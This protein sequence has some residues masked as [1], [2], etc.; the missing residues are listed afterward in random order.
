MESRNEEKGVTGLLNMRNTCYMNAALQALRHNTEL[1]AF[2]LESKHSHWIDRKPSSPNVELVKGYAD[3]LRSLWAG[4]KPAYVRPEGFLQCMHPAAIH[5]GFDQFA[6]PMQHDSHEFL[7]FLLDQLH[8]GMAEEVNIE[9]TRPPP[10]T[11]KEKAIRGALEAWKTTFGKSYSP[12][13]EMIYGLMR[14]SLTCS[15]CKNCTDKWETFNCLKLPIP[16]T[17]DLSGGP[18]DIQSML[19]NELKEEI[20]EG[21]ACDK[22]APERPAVIRKCSIWRLPRMLCLS[23][24]RFTPDGRKIHTPLSFQASTLLTFQQHFTADSPEPSQTQAYECFASVD[25]HG[26]AGGGHYTAQAKSPLTEKWHLFDD[27][28]AYPLAEPQFGESTYILFFKPSSSK[29]A[30]A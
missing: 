15:K 5:A 2:F 11:D 25:H 18:V 10:Q 20:I 23:V 9:I 21:Y 28:T 27:E 12:L 17:L 7:T 3:L 16:Q 1:S 6:V 22:C 4:S 8:E 19:T 30:E 29:A 24:K 13:T 14:V 26:V